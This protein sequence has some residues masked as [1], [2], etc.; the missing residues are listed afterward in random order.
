MSQWKPGKHVIVLGYLKDNAIN[1][2]NYK[3]INNGVRYLVSIQL[4]GI[5]ESSFLGNQQSCFERQIIID[6]LR[7]LKMLLWAEDILKQHMY[8][9]QHGL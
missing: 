6:L 4:T 2:G 9:T 5:L 8:D 7:A 3:N 1:G